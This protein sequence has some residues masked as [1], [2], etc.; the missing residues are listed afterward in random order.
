[1][2]TKIIA[3]LG[4]ATSDEDSVRSLVE[5]G[6]RIFRLNFSHGGKEG[7]IRMVDIIRGLERKLGQTLSILQDLS[8]PKI[9]TCD[10]GL[11]TLEISRGDEVLLGVPGQEEGRSEPVICLDLPAVIRTLKVGDTVALSDGMLQFHVTGRENELLVRMTAENSGIAP[12]RKGIA[13]PGKT[14]P[15]DALTAKDKV[16]LALGLEIGVDVVAMSY[17][18]SAEDISALKAEMRQLGKTLPIIAKL[19][20]RGAIQ[21]LQRILE[22]TDG[23]M[24]ARGDLGLECELSDIPA[25]QKRIISACNAAGKPVIVAT[26]MLLSMVNSPLPTRAETTDVA[27]AILDGADCIMLSEETAIGKYPDKAVAFMRKIAQTAEEFHFESSSGPKAPGD[28][29]HPARFLAYAAALLAQKTRSKA[30]VCH[31]TSGAT[32]RILS[33]CRPKQPVYALSPDPRVRHF[34]NLSWGVVPEAPKESEDSHQDRAETFVCESPAFAAGDCVVIT[35]GQP[36][37]N[38]MQ[39]QTNVVKIFEK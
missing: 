30:I 9:R 36:K 12:P 10:I 23:V 21:N 1:M 25:I 24:V 7:F 2:H 38:Q 4:P 5:A 20:R 14:T 29:E 34:T 31:S 8:G 15:L 13:F 18:Q 22:E 27:N 11:G 19:E 26:Q 35:A 33:A 28:Q 3:T 37:K 17:V 39:T 16:D 6:A 32:A